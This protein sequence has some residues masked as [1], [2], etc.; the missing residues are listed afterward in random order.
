[1]PSLLRTYVLP[2]EPPSDFSPTPP[3]SSLILL[4]VYPEPK[5]HP[6]IHF[7]IHVF[8]L[9]DQLTD[10]MPSYGEPRSSGA[11]WGYPVCL[12]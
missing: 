5:R 7:S 9:F 1:M 8:L 6:N 12:V 2:P 3:F 4:N 10:M 11:I